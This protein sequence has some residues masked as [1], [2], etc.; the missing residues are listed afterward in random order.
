MPLK[1][2]ILPCPKIECSTISPTLKSSKVVTVVR[3]FN[4]ALFFNFPPTI[5]LYKAYLKS[6]RSRYSVGISEIKRLGK[7]IIFS[8]PNLLLLVA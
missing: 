3:T 1:T 6:T 4:F 7:P 5:L 2:I 8:P